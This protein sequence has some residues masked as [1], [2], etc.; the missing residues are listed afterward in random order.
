MPAKNTTPQAEQH[1]LWKF[2]LKNL[3]A[4]QKKFSRDLGREFQR[5]HRENTTCQKIAKAS[6]AKHEKLAA[7]LVKTEKREGGRI[8]RRIA[9]LRGRLGI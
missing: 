3:A 8:H 1:K 2:E 9:I 5:S 7:K 4:T 6:A